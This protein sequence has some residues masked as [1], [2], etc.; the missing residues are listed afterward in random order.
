MRPETQ[1]PDRAR[2]IAIPVR[3]DARTFRRFALFDAFVVKKHWQRP[4]LFSAMLIAFAALALLLRK[5]ESGLIAAVL[6]AVGLGLPLIYV[7]AYLSQVNLQALRSRL[8][9]PRLVYTVTFADEGITVVN[10]QQ[11]EAPLRLNWAQLYRAFRRKRC[12]YLYAAPN[13]AF[14]LPA[15]QAD[16][17]DI[18]VWAFVAAH[19]EKEKVFPTTRRRGLHAR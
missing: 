11:A 14:L 18:E 19:M 6:L 7:G 2:A 3:L 15:G 8:T 4:A 1:M 9:P 16:A 5:G 12:V 17:P 13:R 10:H